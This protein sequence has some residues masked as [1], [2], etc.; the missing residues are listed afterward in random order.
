MKNRNK[1]GFSLLELSVV[2]AVMIIMGALI[3]PRYSAYKKE[4]SMSYARTQIINDVRYVQSYTLST[5]KFSDG[6]SPTG[7]F[8][9]HFV[10][11]ASSYAVFGD[12][13]HGGVQPDHRYSDTTVYPVGSVECEYFETINLVEGVSIT[14][15]RLNKGGV[16]STV[17]SVDYVTLPPYG[18]VYIDATNTNTTLEITFSNGVSGRTEI[19]NMSTSGFIS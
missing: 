6:T 18:K 17:N 19:V 7:G 3:A 16:W 12:K 4:K 14:N 10:K 8:G 9:I 15:L 11:G 1:N 13:I 5:K 2:M